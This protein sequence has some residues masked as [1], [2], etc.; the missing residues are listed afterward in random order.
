MQ[1]AGERQL[2]TSSSPAL[3][4]YNVARRSRR[5]VRRVSDRITQIMIDLIKRAAI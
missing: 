4:G 2:N 1:P 3:N 5:L